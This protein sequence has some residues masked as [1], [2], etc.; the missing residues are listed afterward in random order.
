MTSG[1]L[2]GEGTVSYKGVFQDELYG[3]PA[4]ADFPGYGAAPDGPSFPY[5]GTPLEHPV[6]EGPYNIAEVPVD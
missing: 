1:E 2:I 3:D 5:R 4:D 6:D